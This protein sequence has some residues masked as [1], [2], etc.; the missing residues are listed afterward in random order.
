M[1]VKNCKKSTPLYPHCLNS[2]A[3]RAYHK[4]WSYITCTAAKRL[5]VRICRI[6]LVHKMSEIDNVCGYLFWTAPNIWS[7]ERW[8]DPKL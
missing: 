3:V 5:D 2:L 1:S 8:Q 7:V 6:P 4:F